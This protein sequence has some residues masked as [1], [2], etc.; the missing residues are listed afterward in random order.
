MSQKVRMDMLPRL[1]QRYAGRGRE[2]K[3]L[4]IDEVCGQFGYTRK[5]AIKLLN[6]KAGWGGEPGGRRGRLPKYETAAVEVLQRICRAAE[7]P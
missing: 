4:M 2:G 7:Q 1:R 3:S 5:H 6:A